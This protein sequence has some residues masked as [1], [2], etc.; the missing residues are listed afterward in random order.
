MPVGSYGNF[1]LL[2][3]RGPNGY[4]ARVIRSLAGEATVEFT[5]PFT[6]DELVDFL[7]RS[8]GRG[9]HLGVRPGGGPKASVSRSRCS[10]VATLAIANLSTAVCMFSW[11]LD[12]LPVRGRR[13]SKD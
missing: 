9:R 4:R 8:F 11:P 7:G 5:L 12:H 1:D 2:I 10:I 13:A 3:D 6:D